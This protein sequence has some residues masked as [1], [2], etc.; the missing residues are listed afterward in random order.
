MQA[1]PETGSICGISGCGE[2]AV[3]VCRR[4]ARDFGARHRYVGPGGA[5]VLDLC[6]E[7][8][9]AEAES[10]AH[11]GRRRPEALAG[12]RATARTLVSEGFEPTEAFVWSYRTD[13]TWW[14]FGEFGRRRVAV[15]ER[16]GWPVGDY[17]WPGRVDD[18]T[19][20][21][22]SS[23]VFVRPTYVDP[24][25]EI[26]PLEAT[27][28]SILDGEAFSDEMCA[29]IAATMTTLLHTAREQARQTQPNTD[30]PDRPAPGDL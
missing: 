8:G 17:P 3:G 27:R 16:F 26:A 21:T 28:A 12:I 20:G 6:T 22:S 14:A 15:P 13:S 19:R 9:V 30:R 5:A 24:T 11:A 29:E 25:G 18:A 2:A 7:C 4:C 23:E 10:R 1:Q